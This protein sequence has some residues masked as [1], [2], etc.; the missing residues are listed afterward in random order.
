MRKGIILKIVFFAVIALAF[1]SELVFSSISGLLNVEDLAARFNLNAGTLRPYLAALALL[2]V[3]GGTGALLV[4]WGYV[5]PNASSAGR[6]GV[7]IT[8][9]GMVVYAVYQ[10]AS[11]MFILGSDL[12]SMYIWIGVVYAVMGGVV[13]LIGKSLREP[14]AALPA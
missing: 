7:K 3:V 13:W 4:I 11:G 1:W 10:A 9:I 8:S 2:D 12:Q 5:K 14:Q 6:L